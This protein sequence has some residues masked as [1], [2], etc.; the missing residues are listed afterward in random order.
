MVLYGFG[1]PSRATRV[2]WALEEAG[3]DWSYVATRP[4]DP[5][6]LARHPFGKLPV[7]EDQG[8]VFSESLACCTYVADRF[9][10]AGL[11]PE[12]RTAERAMYLQWCA[13]AV[14]EL[15][16]PLWTK[17]KH[18]FHHPEALRAEVGPAVTAEF[19]RAVE[20][21]AKRLG[22]RTTLVGDQFTCADILVV[23]TLGWAQGARM[24]DLIPENV[25]AY[26][27]LH[28]E[29]SA[30]ARANARESGQ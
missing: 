26:A 29:R 16:Q 18:R 7:L 21:L 22:T 15:E 30:F 23:H 8:H 27:A 19:S 28:R 24:G 25:R 14:S 13:F 4:R 2:A 5:D 3:A 12:P 1:S 20:Y 11:A 10:Q 17:A 9:P 6:L